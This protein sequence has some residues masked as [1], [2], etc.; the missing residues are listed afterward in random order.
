MRLLADCG[1]STLKLGLAHGGGVWLHERVAPDEE[2]LD[3]FLAAHRDTVSGLAILPGSRA[4]GELVERWWRRVGGGRPVQVVGRDIRVPEAGQYPGFGLDRLAAGLVACAQEHA[5]VVVVDAGTATTF[6]AWARVE[7]AARLVGG[8]ILPGARACIAGLAAQAPALPAVEPRFDAAT[9]CQR[10]TPGAI[11]AAVG[12][13]YPAMVGACLERLKRD[14]GI[15]RVV[16]TGGAAAPLLGTVVPRQAYRP[17]LVLE[18][19]E[20]LC[21]A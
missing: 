8:L 17:A 7:D 14:S 12:I 16:V 15:D 4:H 18:G 21:R 13:G 6:T 2:S 3:R 1:N 11:G 10:D 20:L 19:I 5:A 9:A